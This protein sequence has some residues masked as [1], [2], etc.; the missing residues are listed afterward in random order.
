[1]T[2]VR[3]LVLG[4]VQGVGFRWFVRVQAKR[5]GLR[6]FARNLRD[7]SVEVIVD[8]PEAALSQLEQALQ[9]GPAAAQVDRVEKSDVPHEVVIPNGFNIK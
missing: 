8:G 3:F 5:L 9:R 6:G 1:V 4:L 7:G 2:A